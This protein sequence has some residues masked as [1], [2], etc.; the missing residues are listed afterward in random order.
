LEPPGRKKK[1]TSGLYS[2]SADVLEEMRGSHPII[3]LILEHR[4]LSKLKNTYVDA[5]PLTIN[6]RTGRVHTSFNQ[7]G[8][9]TGR[10]AS[11]SPNLQNIPTRTELGRKV[12]TAF[13]ADPD[14]VLLSVDYSQIELRI[15][16][17]MAQDEG[18]LAAFRAGQDIHATTAAAL[19]LRYFTGYQRN[20]STCQSHQFRTDLWH[21]SLWLKSIGEPF[22]ERS[23]GVCRCLL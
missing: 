20:A 14:H 12:R 16:A 3:D 9:V 22:P 21:E 8:A 7:T 1:T 17:H 23:G 18:M 10:L 5:L 11:S 15:V 19:R 2:T 4:E 13:I 6:H